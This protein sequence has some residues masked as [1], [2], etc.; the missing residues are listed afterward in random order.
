MVGTAG[1]VLTLL[2]TVR[3]GGAPILKPATVAEMMKDQAGVQA[4]TQGPGWGFGYGWAVLDDPAVAKTPQG[5][6]TLAWGGVYGHNWFVDPKNRLTV[7]IMTNT[8]FEGMNGPFTT[9]VRDAVYG[10]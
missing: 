3:Q 10:R 6:G 5:A 8:A 9:Q 2:E 7:V 4:A 1:D